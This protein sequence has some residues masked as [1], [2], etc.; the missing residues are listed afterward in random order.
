MTIDHLR[1]MHAHYQEKFMKQQQHVEGLRNEHQSTIALLNTRTKEL[2]AAQ[3]YLTKADAVSDADVCQMVM[4]LNSEV[5]Q[6]AASIAD[7]YDSFAQV[8]PFI[9]RPKV[10]RPPTVWIDG[11]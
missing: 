6:I 3:V 5:F 11:W 8:D 1:K 10:D 9:E 2:R 7:M 4:N